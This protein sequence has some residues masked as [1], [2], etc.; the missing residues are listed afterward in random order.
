MLNITLNLMEIFML[1]RP[2][3][4]PST[5]FEE[6]FKEMYHATKN[7]REKPRYLALFWL[8]QGEHLTSIANRLDTSRKSVGNWLKR[9][10]QGG[11]EGLRERTI[12]GRPCQLSEE[13]MRILIHIVEELQK[14]QP[15]G[16]VMGKHIQQALCDRG[17]S[18]SLSS[19]Y[20]WLHKAGLSWV[21]SRSQHPQSNPEVQQ[22][23]KKKICCSRAVGRGQQSCRK[24]AVGLVSR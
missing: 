6:P 10:L 20:T 12:P 21:T 1:G 7:C 13:R 24:T 9:Y 8:Q 4:L 11:C 17:V 18:C 22:H 14:Q 15:G 3:K 16:R 5:F 19:V 2:I 23:F